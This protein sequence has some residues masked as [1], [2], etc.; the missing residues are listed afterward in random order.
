MRSCRSWPTLE[1]I[2]VDYSLVLPNLYIDFVTDP[3]KRPGQYLVA[4]H[5][6]FGSSTFHLSSFNPVKFYQGLAEEVEE[7]FEDLF[8]FRR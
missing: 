6:L 8:N 2:F 4:S 1:I 7:F 5:P 3:F